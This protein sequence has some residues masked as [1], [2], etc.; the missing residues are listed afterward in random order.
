MIKARQA[1][2]KIRA[3][4]RDKGNS[5]SAAGVYL[6]DEEEALSLV[7]LE[8]RPRQVIW[9]RRWAEPDFQGDVTPEATMAVAERSRSESRRRFV[10]TA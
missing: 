1:R 3:V 5:E 8:L 7:R 9:C 10:L 2:E 6:P 4:L